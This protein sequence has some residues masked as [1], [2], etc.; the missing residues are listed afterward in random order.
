METPETLTSVIMKL[1][2]LAGLVYIG[3][4][5]PIKT[6]MSGEA[7]I[8]KKVTSALSI[9]FIG[10]PV[11]TFV[12]FGLTEFMIRTTQALTYTPEPTPITQKDI[13]SAHKAK[14]RYREYAG[15]PLAFNGFIPSF[16][17]KPGEQVKAPPTLAI[18][19]MEGKILGIA[20]QIGVKVDNDPDS[21][22]RTPG[23]LQIDGESFPLQWATSSTENGTSYST[24]KAN[25]DQAKAMK[26]GVWAKVSFQDDEG[27]KAKTFGL[28]GSRSAITQLETRCEDW[29]KIKPNETDHTEWHHTPRQQ[30]D[31]KI[32]HS[33]TVHESNNTGRARIFHFICKENAGTPLSMGI[34][35]GKFIDN[36]GSKVKIQIKVDEHPQRSIV[37]TVQKT[38]MA[39]VPMFR[40]D[41]PWLQQMKT[42]E[43]VDVT[44]KPSRGENQNLSFRLKNFS[45][46]FQKTARHCPDLSRMRWRINSYSGTKLADGALQ[47]KGGEAIYNQFHEKGITKIHSAWIFSYHRRSMAGIQC[48]ETLNGETWAPMMAINIQPASIKG[49]L[50]L[51]R[52]GEKERQ[53]RKVSIET[54]SGNRLQLEGE[55]P[56]EIPTHVNIHGVDASTIKTLW[57]TSQFETTV[58]DHNGKAYTDTFTAKGMKVALR[59]LSGKC[60]LPSGWDQ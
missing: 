23:N 12:L 57:R 43:K 54:I 2:L 52:I 21:E 41:Q 49:K 17:I 53:K 20:Y 28:N 29:K 44:I 5:L 47:E 26:E 45:E 56:V 31:G 14:W 22:V 34:T 36:E 48:Q 42:G 37:G 59:E 3:H 9:A 10:I 39:L 33:A 4:Y 46:A 58:H 18:T 55:V 19:C 8:I 6:L 30:N 25:K 51:I 35:G 16:E 50:R 13:R 24:W 38:S 1:G 40:R 32:L 7:T 11:T 60:D 27:I 15:H